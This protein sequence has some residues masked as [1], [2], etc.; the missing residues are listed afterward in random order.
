MIDNDPD[1]GTFFQT[2]D[3]STPEPVLNHM[4][5]APSPSSTVDTCF[6]VRY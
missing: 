1:S 4:S 3:E 6:D 2:I 5:M